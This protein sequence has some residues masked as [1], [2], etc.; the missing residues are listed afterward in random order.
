METKQVEFFDFGAHLIS[1]WQ[2]FFS[3]R[4]CSVEYL[5][6]GHVADEPDCL[7]HSARIRDS[8]VGELSD[9]AVGKEKGRECLWRRRWC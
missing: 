9:V 2:P 1:G 8:D 7:P 4:Y 6:D 5:R 3:G